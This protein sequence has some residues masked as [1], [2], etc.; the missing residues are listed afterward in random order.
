LSV[1]DIDAVLNKQSGLKGVCG[2]GDMRDIHAARAKSEGRA[3]LAFEMFCRRIRHY[4]GAYLAEL[5]RVDALVFTAGIGENDSDVRAQVCAGL[6]PLG[7]AIDPEANA[8][9]SRQARDVAAHDSRTRI[10]VVPT[11]EELEI[12][13]E[14]VSVVRNGT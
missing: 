1:R 3:Q 12:A 9:R 7:I 5:G 11:N 13:N 2:L 10:L 8:V 6:A 4:L 14:T